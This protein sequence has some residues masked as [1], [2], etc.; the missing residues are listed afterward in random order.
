MA[1]A[2]EASVAA[3]WLRDRLLYPVCLHW[4]LHIRQF[5]PR[6]TAAVGRNDGTRRHLL[7]VPAVNPDDPTCRRGGRKARDTQRAARWPGCGCPGVAAVAVTAL[8]A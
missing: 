6:R 7:C 1:R 2:P 5:H 3:R 4:H 8:V